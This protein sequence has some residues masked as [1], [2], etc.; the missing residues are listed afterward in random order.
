M[1]LCSLSLFTVFYNSGFTGT[2]CGGAWKS[3]TG[4]NSAFFYLGSSTPRYNCHDLALTHVNLPTNV[5]LG[6]KLLVSATV[7]N[8]GKVPESNVHVTAAVIGSS[9][10]IELIYGFNNRSDPQGCF[11]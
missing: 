2:L 7:A 5:S 11:F 8:N 3:L 1:F 10:G 4:M 9:H 6:G